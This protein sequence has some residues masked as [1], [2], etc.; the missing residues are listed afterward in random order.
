MLQDD[1]ALCKIYESQYG[2]KKKYEIIGQ[3]NRRLRISTNVVVNPQCQPSQYHQTQSMQPSFSPNMVANSQCQEMQDVALLTSMILGARYQANQ[4]S[5]SQATKVSS[6]PYMIDISQC[7]R[8]SDQFQQMQAS[9]LGN[10]VAAPQNQPNQSQPMKAL[11][12]PYTIGISQCQ[13]SQHYAQAQQVQASSPPDMVAMP[14]QMQDSLPADMFDVP[15]DQPNKH[16]HSQMEDDSDT[17][18]FLNFD[19]DVNNNL[20]YL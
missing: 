3:N 9:L 20:E 6:S 8:H 7:Q 18:D 4:H 13:S 1:W 10:M 14:Q 17:C 19:P 11:L 5:Q 12:S 2:M 15:Q 16:F